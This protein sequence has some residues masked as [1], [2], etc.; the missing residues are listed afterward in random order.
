MKHLKT[1]QE[2]NEASENL[3][4]SDVRSSKNSQEIRLWEIIDNLSNISP[5]EREFFIND[6]GVVAYKFHK[7]S[8]ELK[9]LLDIMINSERI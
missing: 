4:I 5:E 1:P 6:S 9:N 3:N 8:K 7:T 2:L